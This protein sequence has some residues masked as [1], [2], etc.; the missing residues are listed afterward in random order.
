MT[1]SNI[2]NLRVE[3]AMGN[4]ARAELS[5]TNELLKSLRELSIAQ[6]LSTDPEMIANRERLICSVQ[7]LDLIVEAL[8]NAVDRGEGA[9]VM[10][11]DILKDTHE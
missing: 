8:N 6:I 2:E 9:E 10:L 4:K 1:D 11:K 7:V 5:L 3:M